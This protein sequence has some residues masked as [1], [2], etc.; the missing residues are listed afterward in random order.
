ISRKFRPNRR[1]KAKNLGSGTAQHTG[2]DARLD[3]SA[4]NSNS[5]RR[6]EIV[7]KME[8]ALSSG[9]ERTTNAPLADSSGQTLQHGGADTDMDDM[10]SLDDDD[11]VRC[12]ARLVCAGMVLSS[13]EG[14]FVSMEII[15][16]YTVV[17]FLALV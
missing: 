1:N 13:T 5:G 12:I 16:V 8:P 3:A 14:V 10:D 15:N 4:F 9:V 11:V 6:S 2:V 7:N 17:D